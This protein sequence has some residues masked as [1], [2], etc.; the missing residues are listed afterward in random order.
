MAY[1][2]NNTIALSVSKSSPY[3][4]GIIG[5]I[6]VYPGNMVRLKSTGT[7]GYGLANEINLPTIIATEN[8]YAGG[9]IADE[10]TGELIYM[11]HLRPGDVVLAWLATSQT[12]V[13]GTLLTFSL[14]ESGYLAERTLADE[15]LVATALEPVTT[16]GSAARIK[17]SISS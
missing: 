14:G 3:I 1:A 2:D 15:K 11:R 8:I 16:V 9:T 12:V 13:I 10:Y 7:G 6:T 17:V 5:D 4:E